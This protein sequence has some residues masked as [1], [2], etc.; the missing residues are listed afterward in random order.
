MKNK[1]IQAS[2]VLVII[3]GSIYIGSILTKP[4]LAF[5]DTQILVY[6]YNGMQEAHE[7]YQQKKLNWESEIDSLKSDFQI[8][9]DKFNVQFNSLTSQEKEIKQNLLARQEASLNK[10]IN[11]FNERANK[12]DLELTQGVL[13][14]INAFVI[15][16]GNEHGY[17]M[18]F[19]STANGNLLYSKT[20]YNITDDVL[21][22]LNNKF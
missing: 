7:K 20:A 11:S 22:E 10:Y 14:Q 17:D 12:E 13:N 5:V 4:K 2:I 3:L 15:E 21:K 19:G 18:I 6:S 16:Y 9:V 8:S 1:I